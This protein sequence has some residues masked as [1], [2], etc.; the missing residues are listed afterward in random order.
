VIC[1]LLDAKLPCLCIDLVLEYRGQ[2]SGEYYGRWSGV[3]L[4]VASRQRLSDV[5]DDPDIQVS[6][7]SDSMPSRAGGHSR[8]PE[9]IASRWHG[10]SRAA[11]VSVRRGSDREL[12]QDAA[13]FAPSR[14]G[15]GVIAKLH[16]LGAGRWLSANWYTSFR[17]LWRWIVCP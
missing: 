2:R 1:P 16:R 3:F 12:R 7:V 5:E 11:M 13:S 10:H 15:G 9:S 17:G 14:L 6:H 8:P 4:V